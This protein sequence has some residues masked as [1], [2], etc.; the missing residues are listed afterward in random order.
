MCHSVGPN[1]NILPYPFHVM[2]KYRYIPIVFAYVAFA[3]VTLFLLPESIVADPSATNAKP[4][5]ECRPAGK[6]TPLC[7]EKSAD[8]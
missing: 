8:P 6:G 5:L 1:L 4:T 7:W 2:T 3:G